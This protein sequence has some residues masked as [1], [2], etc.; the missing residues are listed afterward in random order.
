M[1]AAGNVDLGRSRK[2]LDAIDAWRLGI[3]PR[4]LLDP[5][6]HELVGGLLNLREQASGVRGRGR[7][8]EKHQAVVG[9]G[10]IHP[11]AG[12][13]VGKGPHVEDGIV[14][15]QR[16][17]EAVLALGGTVAGAL[18]A[19]ELCEHRTDVADEVDVGQ[20][21]G[22]DHADRQIAEDLRRPGSMNDANCALA[23]G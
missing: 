9:A 22:A 6:T 5:A 17:L 19:A 2:D 18:I 13:V 7:C 10:E 20:V 14:A 16:Q 4:P 23:I 12:M 11:T 15:T 1:P 8:L 21:A 3:E